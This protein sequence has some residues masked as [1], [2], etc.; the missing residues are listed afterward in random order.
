MQHLINS[1]RGAQ[2]PTTE[3]RLACCTLR[4]PGDR[5]GVR[6]AASCAT[7]GQEAAINREREGSKGHANLQSVTLGPVVVLKLVV[8]GRR[9]GATLH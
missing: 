1:L 7:E 4:R 6:L 9:L 8:D 3:R 2:R 5:A